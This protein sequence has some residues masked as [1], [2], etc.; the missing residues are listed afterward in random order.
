MDRGA[1]WT[2]SPW[3]LKELDTIE[4]LTPAPPTHTHGIG[5]Q[6]PVTPGRNKQNQLWRW[7]PGG[8]CPVSSWQGTQRHRPSSLE[9]WALVGGMG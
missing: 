7:R 1:W 8:G 3:E 4:R 9:L 6:G 2:N 5:T